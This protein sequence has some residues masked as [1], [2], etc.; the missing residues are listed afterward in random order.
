MSE[1][2]IKNRFHLDEYNITNY[3]PNTLKAFNKDVNKFVLFKDK[4]DFFHNIEEI[5][6]NNLNDFIS[7]IS[8]SILNNCIK[9]NKNI[10]KLEQYFYN[11]ISSFGKV[12]EFKIETKLI[13]KCWVSLVSC[14]KIILDLSSDPLIKSI[15]ID[16]R[17]FVQMN[18]I[19]V[20]SKNNNS[21][22]FNIPLI[23][24]YK[25]YVDVL[26]I[27]PDSIIPFQL[28]TVYKTLIKYYKNNLK[29]IH[30]IKIKSESKYFI[31]N[32]NNTI[33]SL[34]NKQV[35]KEYIDF[36]K[37]NT[38]NCV[39]CPLKCTFQELYQIRYDLIPFNLNKKK[40]IIHSI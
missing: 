10:N 24:H 25:D 18:H 35:D 13:A 5:Y 15:E 1:V 3:C 26:V 38:Y 20:C 9:T 29:N 2:S 11:V 23:F 19:N 17:H 40:I 33:V 21:Y 37:I 14:F 7:F 8:Y 30:V 12:K 32:V 6:E 28:R 22:Y 34:V 39:I 16:K 36:N 4:L 31:L 27:T